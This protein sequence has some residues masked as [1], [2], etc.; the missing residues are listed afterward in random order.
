ML[1]EFHFPEHTF[2]L[3]LFLQGA[4]RLIDIVVA[5]LNLH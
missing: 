5:N 3:E 2:A 1:P 4:E